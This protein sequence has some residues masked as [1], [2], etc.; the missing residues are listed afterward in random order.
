MYKLLALDLDGTLLDRTSHVS[1]ENARAV[2]EAQLAGVQVVLCTGRHLA[3]VQMFHEQL[4]A[5][6]DWAVTANGAMVCRMDGTEEIAWA[7]LDETDCRTIL[8][9]CD[10]HGTDPSF[11]TASQ[12]YF[13]N[14]FRRLLEILRKEGHKP[15]ANEQDTT[16]YIADM[17]GWNALLTKGLRFTKAILFDE[18]PET[19]DRIIAALEQTE[20]FELAPSIMYGGLLKDVEVN[21]KG[22]HK[23]AGLAQL[24]A[25]LGF[26][27]REVMAIGDS[28]NDLTMLRMA[29]LGVA[30]GY[31]GAH[32]HAA[33]DVSTAENTENG[34]AKAI[35]QYL[36][37]G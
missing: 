6:V 37:R 5:P 8:D 13:G 21:R 15:S 23:G 20:R 30:M 17:D 14:G 11:Y 10:R 1:E 34:V 26:T 18:N 24:A 28:D 32:I 19:V 3:D 29:G 12:T 16:G 27:M 31:A 7:G 2:R 22:V 33:A 35:E 36:L 4:L 9:V 25:H